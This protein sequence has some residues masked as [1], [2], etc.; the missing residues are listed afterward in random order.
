MG[1][2]NDWYR[3]YP[4][5]VDACVWLFRRL[6]YTI[7]T[8]EAIWFKFDQEKNPHLNPKE[9]GEVAECC[10]K[11]LKGQGYPYKRADVFDAVNKEK[12]AII[13]RNAFE[14]YIKK[15]LGIDSLYGVIMGIM[16]RKPKRDNVQKYLRNHLTTDKFMLIDDK[17]RRFT[18]TFIQK[19]LIDLHVYDEPLNAAALKEVGRAL[20]PY[21]E[22]L[23]IRV[24][25]GD[26]EE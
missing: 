2:R 7:G 23:K 26:I 25:S 9:R 21:M 6:F 8:H 16:K 22:E 11:F 14:C 5:T 17:I 24:S 19:M 1:E 18:E 4:R 3:K 15:Q 13:I 12:H 10:D 20:Q